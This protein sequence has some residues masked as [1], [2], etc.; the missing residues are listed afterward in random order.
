[1]LLL[2]F[3]YARDLVA[4]DIVPSNSQ[5]HTQMLNLQK[6]EGAATLS[7]KNQLEYY[8]G[9]MLIPIS[10]LS[11]NNA[12]HLVIFV[13]LAVFVIWTKHDLAEI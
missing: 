4:R 2:I 3:F 6:L 5:P 11:A 1:M 8:D 13:P 10:M 7:E 9:Y 12:S